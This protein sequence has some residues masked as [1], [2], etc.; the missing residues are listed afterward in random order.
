MKKVER[1]IL[2][3]RVVHFYSNMC[4]KNKVLTYKHFMAEGINYTTIRNIILR[5]E[6][7]GTAITKSPPGAKP[8][9]QNLNL[10]ERI[11]KV[12]EKNRSISCR[13]AALKLHISKSHYNEIKV[14]KL[15]IKAYRKKLALK[16]K[17]DQEIRAKKAC[18]KIYRQK[19]LKNPTKVLIIDDET[20]VPE[21]PKLIPGVEF[22][23]CK[24]RSG[25]PV[26]QTLKA[27]EKFPKKYLIWQAIDEHGNASCPYVSMGTMTGEI[28]LKE[29]L[30]KRLL[31]FI[32]KHHKVED[33][34]L[35]MDLAPAHY[36][37]E[38][39]EWL[40]ANN[41][42]FITKRDNA[43]NVPQA[44]PIEKFWAICKAEY[45]K[46]KVG[47]KNVKS[48]AKIWTNISN[49]KAGESAQ[50]LM[51]EARRNLRAIAYGGVRAPFKVRNN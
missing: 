35:W 17:G 12:I 29:C 41:I 32:K 3:T 25:V 10:K 43:P 18:R 45:K 47:A 1:D 5:Y 37:A 19:V 24:N 28:Y 15:G 44:R 13:N 38:V 23:H 33:I 51:K 6:E 40:K 48:M 30:K 46:R 4:G 39:I 36:K 42:D 49:K 20:Y 11:K 2:A 9:P 16:Y 50:K 26:E 8:K 22:Y 31:P 21:D 27:K 14:H 7:R 34:V